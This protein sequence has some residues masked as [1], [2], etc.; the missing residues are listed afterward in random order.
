MRRTP[1]RQET[2]EALYAAALRALTRRAHSVHEMRKWL[3]QRAG[4][5]QH[6]G[7]VLA[8]LKQRGYL[9]DAR[10]AKQY[11]RSRVASRRLGRFRVARDLRA[12]GVPD[13]HIEAALDEVFAETDQSAL[14]RQRIQ[15][16]LRSLRGKSSSS[17]NA[18]LDASEQPPATASTTRGAAAGE[19]DRRRLASLYSSLLRAGFPADL[20]R[21]ELQAIKEDAVL[22]DVEPPEAANEPE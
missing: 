10:Y 3:E 5:N 15:R 18:G 6:V 14:L 4:D 1:K 11:A 16:K 20:I 8:R 13:R 19:L 9:D 2:E 17:P 22:P 12:R 7:A 21:R